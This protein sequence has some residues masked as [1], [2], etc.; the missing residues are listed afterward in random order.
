MLQRPNPLA[1]RRRQAAANK[2][3]KHREK[4]FNAI[5]RPSEFVVLVGPNRIKCARATNQGRTGFADDT[6][7]GQQSLHQVSDW[8]TAGDGAQDHDPAQNCFALASTPN[9]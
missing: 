2:V 3:L 9:Y 6:I 5:I 7:V 1:N 8:A 4:I